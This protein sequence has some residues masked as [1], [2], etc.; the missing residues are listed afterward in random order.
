MLTRAKEKLK[1]CFRIKI[2]RFPDLLTSFVFVASFLI[3]ILL[4]LLAYTV[5]T[6]CFHLFEIIAGRAKFFQ[7]ISGR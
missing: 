2:F 1:E 4:M 7:E 6:F 3:L 5:K